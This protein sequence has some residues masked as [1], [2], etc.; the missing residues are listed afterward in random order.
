MPLLPHSCF[1]P[2]PYRSWHLQKHLLENLRSSFI[3]SSGC[4]LFY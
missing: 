1:P 4:F 3:L 2:R